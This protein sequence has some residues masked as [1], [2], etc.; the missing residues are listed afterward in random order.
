MLKTAIIYLLATC[1]RLGSAG[2]TRNMLK[3]QCEQHVGG[4]IGDS[5]FAATL[6][7]LQD[8][9]FV[10]FTTSQLSGDRVYHITELGRTLV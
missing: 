9:Q 10:S 2:L 3:A 1:Q 7:E 4:K 8:Q 5:D 6:G